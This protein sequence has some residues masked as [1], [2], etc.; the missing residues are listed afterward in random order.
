VIADVSAPALFGR[1]LPP[2]AVSDRVRQQV[3]SFVWDT[4]LV[5][6]N[7]A[8]NQPIPW[9][10]DSLHGTGT[11]HLGADNAGLVR[12]MADLTTGEMP[13]R[14]FLLLGQMTTADPTRSP[15]GTESAWAYTHLPRGVAD[16]SNAE[17]LAEAMDQVI[18][19]HAPG[20]GSTVSHRMVQ[21]PSDLAAADANLH[22]GAVNGGTAQLFQQMI[23]RPFPGMGRA[24]TPIERLY[25]GSAATHPGGSVHGACGRN[26]AMAALA[27]D[28]RAGWLRRRMARRLLVGFTGGD[29]PSHLRD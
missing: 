9:I 28:A 27:G 21:R 23:F 5:K 16:D 8:L 12:W 3:R 25:L 17:Q 7:Y 4:P 18:E 19:D 10:S 22:D 20:F 2:E 24:E 26:A 6:V 15:E 29:A 14:P 13:R 11:V 1:L